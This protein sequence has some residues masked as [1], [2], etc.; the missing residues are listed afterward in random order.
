MKVK[1]TQKNER[2]KLL[3]KEISSIT[4]NLNGDYE[5]EAG[6]M[7]DCS[8]KTKKATIPV[9]MRIINSIFGNK[10]CTQYL[11]KK[12]LKNITLEIYLD[13]EDTPIFSPNMACWK[14]IK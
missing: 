10:Q 6:Q 2:P 8:K 12:G 7:L 11:T 14:D 4:F 5:N 9:T 1:H 3:E 13:K